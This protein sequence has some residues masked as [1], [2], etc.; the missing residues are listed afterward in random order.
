MPESREPYF[1][2]VVTAMVTPFDEA[3]ALDVEA[4]AGLARWLTEHGSNGLVVAGTT[5]E[6]S[7]L[8]DGERRD[9]WTAVAE[10]VTVPVVAGAGTNDTLHSIELTKIAT[11]C[12]VDGILAVTPYYSR[13]SQQGIFE[14]FAALS[15]AT[16]LPVMLY[17]IPVRT[18]R[19]IA[20]ETLLRLA[21]EVPNVVALKD[22]AGDVAATARLV[23]RAPGSFQVYSGDDAL[24]LPLLA[25]GAVGVVSVASH[26][27]GREMGA[28]IAAASRGDLGG[29]RITNARLLDSFAFESSEAFPNP[30][31][32]KALL[33]SLGLPVGQ[34]RPP[35]G[36]AGAELEHE[37]G[38]MLH[39]LGE[40]VP[41][42]PAGRTLG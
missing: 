3:G 40:L 20:A 27:V 16:H 34:C 1:G 7:V 12:G 17:D 24:T 37:A 22:A 14:H 33:R 25:V 4:A 13:P 2:S 36:P 35:M 30:L 26:W 21:G 10:A 6:G 42:V 19:R 8:S 28:M 23:A 39:R 29:A 11:A 32:T 38:Q 9:L 18:G 15:A 41:S 31:P 5:G